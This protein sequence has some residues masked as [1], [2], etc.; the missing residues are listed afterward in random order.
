VRRIV[1]D[2]T[3][4]VGVELDDG[5]HIEA[6]HVLSSA[7][8]LETLRLCDRVDPDVER[9]AG[10]LSFVE[11]CSVLDR[12]PRELGIERTIVF[13]N[14]EDRFHWRRPRELVDPRSGVLCMPSNYAFDEPIDEPAVRATSLADFAGWAALPEER[15][16][17]AKCEWYDVLTAQAARLLGEFRPHTVDSDMFTPKTVVHYTGHVN[18]A[19]YGAARKRYDGATFLS[20]VSLCGTDQGMVGIVGALVGGITAANGR[21]LQAAKT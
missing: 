17:A 4:A 13:F 16:R 21:V 9:T 20:N 19:I 3:T 2:G 12:S 14:T 18:G 8:H 1:H 15:Y 11:T 7:G 5:E 6:A 10:R